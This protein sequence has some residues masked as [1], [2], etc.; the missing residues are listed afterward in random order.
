M[1]SNL[2]SGFNNHFEEFLDSVHGVFPED[3]DVLASRNILKQIRK[4]NP[5]LIIKIWKTYIVD[6]YE[7]E[8]KSGEISFFI[9]KDYSQDLQKMESA[10]KIL[11]GINRLRDPIKQM[12]SNNQK[13]AMKYIQN[14][15][16]ITKLYF[17]GQ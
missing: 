1:S 15:S 16:K 5:K 13:I 12:G 10:S 7:S 2:L 8:I 11:D 3:A 4:A 6:K 9:E 14:L 17:T